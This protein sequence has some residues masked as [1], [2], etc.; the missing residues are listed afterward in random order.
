MYSLSEFSLAD[1]T[2]CGSKLRKMG[3]NDRIIPPVYAEDF[4]GL[5]A[6]AQVSIMPNAGHLLMIER[7]EVFASSVANFLS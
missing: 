2:R 7:A 5:V 6:G 3:E 1:M 4:S